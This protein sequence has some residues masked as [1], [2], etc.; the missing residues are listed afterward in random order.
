[1]ETLVNLAVDFLRLVPLIL[2]FYI[3]VL[4]GTVLWSERPEAYRLKAGLWLVLGCGVILGI[5]L[6]FTSNSVA[7]TLSIIGASMLQIAVA[8]GLAVLTVYKLAD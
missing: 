8:L 2:V 5:Q 7:Q 4:I 3:P 1:M 6:L